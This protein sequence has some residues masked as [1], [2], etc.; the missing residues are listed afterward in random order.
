[1]NQGA[2]REFTS[3]DLAATREIFCE[4]ATWVGSEICFAAF[5]QELAELPGRYVP[6]EG[7]LLLAFFEDRLA[8]CVALRRLEPEIGEMKRLYVRPGFQGTGLGR[9]L[10][11]RVIAEARDAHYKLLRLDTMPRLERAVAMYRVRGFREIP[12][13]GDNP[14][15]ALCFELPL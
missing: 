9:L 5:E 2:I 10:V 4:Y 1:M 11:D 12:P 3:E 14:K 6:P 8:G 7:R 15:E 13:Y